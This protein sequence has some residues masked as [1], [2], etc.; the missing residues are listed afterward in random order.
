MKC[1]DIVYASK[2]QERTKTGS[3][4]I[5][6]SG[7]SITDYRKFSGLMFVQMPWMKPEIWLKENTS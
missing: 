6:V 2:N 3:V 5:S 1:L 4:C 7:Q